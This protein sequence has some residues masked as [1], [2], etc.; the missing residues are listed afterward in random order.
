MN[1]RSIL[2]RVAAFVNPPGLPGDSGSYPQL[3][4]YPVH[5]VIRCLV[6]THVDSVG[7]ARRRGPMRPGV[8][9]NMSLIRVR[10]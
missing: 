8:D 5:D 2:R 9:F 1:V 7:R 4:D 10:S 6:A 3:R